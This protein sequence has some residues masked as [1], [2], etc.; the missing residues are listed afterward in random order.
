MLVLGGPPFGEEIV[1]WWNFVGRSHEE[2]VAAQASW[3][4]H[5]PRFGY[6]HGYVP[7]DE[8]GSW[9]MVDLSST[10][11]TRVNG[12]RVRRAA[13]LPNDQLTVANIKYHVKFGAELEAELASLRRILTRPRTGRT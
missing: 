10:N 7:R 2:V 3:N 5:E 9:W 11:G 12:Q 1:M 6:V 4:A 13:L 8:D